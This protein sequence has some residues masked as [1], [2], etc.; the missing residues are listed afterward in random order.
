MIQDIK[1]ISI[2]DLINDIE[3]SDTFIEKSQVNYISLINYFNSVLLNRFN[4]FFGDNVICN[5][6]FLEPVLM[7]NGYVGIIRDNDYFY[8]TEIIPKDYGYYNNISTFEIVKNRNSITLPEHFQGVKS[9]DNINNF[10]MYNR[11]DYYFSTPY[12]LNQVR[13]LANLQ[14]ILYSLFEKMQQPYIISTTDKTLD[15]S[16]NNFYQCKLK[17]LTYTD[18]IENIKVLELGIKTEF[19][20]VIQ[21]EINNL[22]TEIHGLLG[23]TYNRYPK[24]ERLINAEVQNQTEIIE[25]FSNS[26]YQ[27]RLKTVEKLQKF[28]AELS[29]ELFNGGKKDGN[30]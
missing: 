2:N 28:G 18:N 25:L 16:R 26:L 8:F 24:K 1:S 15:T 22:F 29:V 13:K 21:E 3:K 4:W 14:T 6:L 30:Q 12:F 7:Q 23:V 17:D 27:T 19:I 20:D 10:V 9:V 5:D 11:K